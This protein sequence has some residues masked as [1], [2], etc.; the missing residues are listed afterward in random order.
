MAMVNVLWI[1]KDG[2][3]I[4]LPEISIEEVF[5]EVDLEGSRRLSYVAPNCHILNG[6]GGKGH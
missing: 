6:L 3:L 1:F 4:V 5:I 2:L